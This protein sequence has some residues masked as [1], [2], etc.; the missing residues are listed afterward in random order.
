MKPAQ[1]NGLNSR[2]AQPAEDQTKYATDFIATILRCNTKAAFRAKRDLV[3]YLFAT[4]APDLVIPLNRAQKRECPGPTGQVA[5]QN[6]DTRH[7]IPMD[8]YEV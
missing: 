8:P 6:T 1:G 7:S 4:V 2:E 3:P 5:K